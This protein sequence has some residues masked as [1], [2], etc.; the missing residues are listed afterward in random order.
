MKLI[1]NDKVI[2]KKRNN[3]KNEVKA[4]SKKYETRLGY[5]FNG[6]FSISF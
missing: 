2:E 5:V 1:N 3:I 4:F 6:Y